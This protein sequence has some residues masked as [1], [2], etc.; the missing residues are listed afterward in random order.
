MK[1]MKKQA[2]Q[3]KEIV[4]EC[5][6]LDLTGQEAAQLCALYR[7]ESG[8]DEL[9]DAITTA[10]YAGLATGTRHGLREAARVAGGTK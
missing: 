2:L 8:I 9:W 4:K 3:G 10:Y 1:D 7:G 6:S 5:K